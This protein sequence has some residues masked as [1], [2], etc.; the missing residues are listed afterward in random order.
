MQ[1]QE[2]CHPEP[3]PELDSESNDFRVSEMLNRVQHAVFMD[4]MTQKFQILLAG[5]LF[6][7]DN[8]ALLILH[9][10]FEFFGM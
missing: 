10:F 5:P 6:C 8:F 3:G 7:N 1:T 4:F 9:W 2:K